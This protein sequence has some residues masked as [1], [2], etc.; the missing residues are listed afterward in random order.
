MLRID[1][2]LLD[3]LIDDLHHPVNFRVIHHRLKNP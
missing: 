1:N 2:P 3:I